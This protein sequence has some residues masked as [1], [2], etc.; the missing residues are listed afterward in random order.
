MIPIEQYTK[1]L[2]KSLSQIE[3]DAGLTKARINKLKKLG[4]KVDAAGQV[5]IKSTNSIESLAVKLGCNPDFDELA[6]GVEVWLIY[7]ER[8]GNVRCEIGTS[9]CDVIEFASGSVAVSSDAYLVGWQ[10]L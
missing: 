4:A 6:D 8:G 1:L 3:R 7:V 9:R 2:D 10:P 5:W